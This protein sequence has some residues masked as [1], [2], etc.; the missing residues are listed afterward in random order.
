MKLEI[1]TLTKTINDENIDF[2]SLEGTEGSLG[3]LPD[4]I[5]MLA[6]LKLAP[7]H[8]L[9]G[10]RTEF[11]AVMG[12]VVRVLSNVVT[13]ITE[14]A[15]KAVEIDALKAQKEKDDAEAYMSRKTEIADMVRAEA[16]LRKAMAKLRT[17]EV[18]KRI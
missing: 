12:G 17:V 8:Y 7:L 4:H 2:V 14:E 9:K 6:E 5:P 13:I 1:I 15:E 10:G 16:Q 11:V 3:I 18:S